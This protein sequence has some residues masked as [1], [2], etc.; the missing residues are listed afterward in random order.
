LRQITVALVGHPN[1]GKTTLFNALT[2]AR[3]YV[4]NW[5]G[6]TVEGVRGAFVFGDVR[7]EVVDLPGTYTLTTPRSLDEQVTADAVA[8]GGF[9]LVVNVVDGPSIERSL[10]LTAQVL[11]SQGGGG[12]PVLIVANRMDRAAKDGPSLDRAALSRTL[13]SPVVEA[14]AARGDGIDALRQAMVD[15][16]GTAPPAFPA[17]PP[18]I[19]DRLDALAREA[20]DG[21]RWTVLRHLEARGDDTSEPAAAAESAALGAARHALVAAAIAAGVHRQAR[22]HRTVTDRLDTLALHPWGGVPVFLGA[23]YL[24]FLWTIHMGGAF[25]D[26]F[27]GV[28]GAVL[29]DGLGG[30][31]TAAGLPAWVVVVIADG[32]GRGVRTIATF[33]PIIACLYLFLSILEE[34]GYMARAAVV[35]DRFMRGIGLPGKAFVPLIVGLGCNVPAVMAARTLE[36]EDDRKATIAMTPFMSCGAR[37][38]VYA[39]FVAAFFPDNGQNLVFLL[40]LLGIAVAVLTG[41]VLKRTLFGGRATPLLVELPSYQA[42]R[43]ASVLR[44]TGDRVAS[45]VLDAGKVIVPVV[46]VLSVLNAVT[47][48]GR[49]ARGESADSVLAAIGKAMTPLF[50]PIGIAEDNWPATVGLFTGLFAKEAVVG[51]LDALYSAQAGAE[52]TAAAP[53]PLGTALRTALATI[54][55]NLGGLAGAVLDPLGIDIGDVGSVDAAAER[56]GVDVAT[57]GALKRNFE[58]GASAFAYLVFVLLYAPCVATVAAIRRESGGAWTAFTL[59]WSTGMG[60]AVATLVYQ[61]LTFA[62]HPARSA[63]S[64]AVVGLA[65][66]AAVRVLRR[67]GGA[68]RLAADRSSGCVTCAKCP[69]ARGA[70]G[71]PLAGSG[72]GGH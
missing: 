26:A 51:T 16:A 32:L 55:A 14:S 4:G 24:M 13:G 43:A 41:F 7:I 1:C 56:Q 72:D 70:N 47:T 50:A 36:S 29:V 68:I 27:D 62:A 5:P 49:I 22:P 42:P 52:E 45:F 37:L 67:A 58:G 30:A 9:D 44:R 54:P 11:E 21:S 20:G 6:V 34:S 10:F 19:L 66:A 33:I 64:I 57:F 53:P 2:G 71:L 31:L 63:L 60:F 35:M 8:N 12:A 3:Q 59:A 39:L 65:F 38:P 23:M 69:P 25:V 28:F 18:A 48:D 40:Y 61:G 17:Y 46:M 15:T